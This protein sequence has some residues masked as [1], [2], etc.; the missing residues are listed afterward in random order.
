MNPYRW[1]IKVVENPEF[2]PV[3]HGW[4]TILWV[5]QFPIVFIFSDLQRSVPY[6]VVIS[7]ASALLGQLSSWQAAR[8]E[9]MMQRKEDGIDN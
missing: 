2:W 6:L 1:F 8:I 9:R 3:F 7:I 5:T 4:V